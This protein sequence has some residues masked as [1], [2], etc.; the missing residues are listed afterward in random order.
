M[1]VTGATT[2]SSTLDVTGDAIL[3]SDLAVT[4]N[5]AVRGMVKKNLYPNVISML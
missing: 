2:L 4:G 5:A 1:G 3:S